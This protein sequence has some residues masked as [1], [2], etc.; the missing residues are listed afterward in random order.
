LTQAHVGE[1]STIF[2]D[3]LPLVLLACL[4]ELQ[5]EPEKVDQFI[6][7]EMIA[8]FSSVGHRIDIKDSCQFIFSFFGSVEK[9]LDVLLN[10]KN[11]PPA[12]VYGLVRL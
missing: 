11:L 4:N 10:S 5:S 8:V 2:S 7:S 9:Q 3:F 12:V 6:K 1:T